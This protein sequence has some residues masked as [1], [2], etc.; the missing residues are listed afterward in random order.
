MRR[1]LLLMSL[2][3]NSA[4]ADGP[5]PTFSGLSAAADDAVVAATNPAAMTLFS[6]RSTRFEV[7]GFASDSTWEGRL[8]PDGPTTTMESDSSTMV[9]VGAVVIPFRDNAWFGFT[10][11][12]SG[13]SEEY[14]EDWAGRYL[15][16]EY[17]LIYV[18]A[19]PSIATRLTDRWSI[20]ASL[21]L[22]YTTYEQRKAV[23]NIDPG[24][25]DGSLAVETDGLSLGYGLSAL[26]ELN[27]RS[28]LGFNYRSEIEPSLDGKAK[29][30]GLGPITEN[31]LE[32]AGLIGARI[33]VS[34]RQPRSFSLGLYH[35]LP[36][37]HTLTLDGA[38]IDFSRFKLAEVFVEGE[39]IVSNEQN[40][41]DALALSA[42][43]SWPINDRTRLGIG[44]FFVS[45]FVGQANRTM[46]FRM[47]DIWSVGFGVKWRWRENRL[48]N[49]SLN[50]L[51]I[52]D[53]PVSSPV[54]PGLGQVV[55][56][57]TS[58]DTVYFRASISFGPGGG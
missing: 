8:E 12:G 58:R 15:L 55:G 29:F 9:P 3:V 57:Y 36:N 23:P 28:R 47:D 25:G 21:A 24:Y 26:Y 41:D 46:A 11:L 34:S 31:L 1:L 53:A 16:Q 35:D 22:T 38:W 40:F 51:T 44:G 19:Y 39:Q 52:G 43:Y 27:S 7:L 18:S 54:I 2:L 6:E 30:S 5:Y 42:S 50:Y 37:Q 33:D 10:V 13:F 17:E 48:I 4:L 49:A 45:D 56:R 32:R 14:D 20:A